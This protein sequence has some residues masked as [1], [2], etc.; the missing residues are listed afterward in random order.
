MVTMCSA[1]V[2]L[3]N[4]ENI[5]RVVSQLFSLQKRENSFLSRLYGDLFHTK[6]GDVLIPHP[7]CIFYFIYLFI[8]YL[9]FINLFN[10]T[11]SLSY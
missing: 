4:T 9:L 7:F 1:S 10:I 2:F 8:I 5:L 3:P 6:G 11:F